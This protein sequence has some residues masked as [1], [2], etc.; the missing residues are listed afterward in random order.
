MGGYGMGE[1]DMFN[2]DIDKFLDMIDDWDLKLKIIMMYFL[3]C[4]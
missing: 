4:A 2:E 3:K 1:L